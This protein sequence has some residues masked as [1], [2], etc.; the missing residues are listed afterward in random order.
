LPHPIDLTL[1]TAC[2]GIPG[3]DLAIIVRVFTTGTERFKG[4]INKGVEK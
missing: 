1:K 3:D 4:L 2:E